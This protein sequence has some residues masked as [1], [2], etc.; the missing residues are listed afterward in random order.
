MLASSRLNT[1]MELLSFFLRSGWRPFRIITSSVLQ[2]ESCARPAKRQNRTGCHQ[3]ERQPV[4]NG[5]LDSVEHLPMWGPRSGSE[6]FQV[7]HSMTRSA[8]S[9]P[10]P[11]RYRGTSLD[12]GGEPASRHNAVFHSHTT[13]ARAKDWSWERSITNLPGLSSCS[14]P[15][16]HLFWLVDRCHFGE[17]MMRAPPSCQAHRSAIGLAK[18]TGTGFPTVLEMVNAKTRYDPVRVPFGEHARAQPCCGRILR[19]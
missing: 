19:R 17:I 11:L 15:V 6:C 16:T 13:K 14:R 4:D 10:F 3:L 2:H 9:R 12:D 5:R 18:K 7:T 8:P 1:P